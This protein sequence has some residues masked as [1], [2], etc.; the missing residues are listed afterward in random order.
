MNS[1]PAVDQKGVWPNRQCNPYAAPQWPS[2]PSTFGFLTSQ[3]CFTHPKSYVWLP[4]P[5]SEPSYW[6]QHPMDRVQLQ[7]LPFHRPSTLL[8]G[9]LAPAIF[10]RN[11]HTCSLNKRCPCPSHV[12]ARQILPTS[13]LYRYLF[14]LPARHTQCTWSFAIPQRAYTTV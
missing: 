3:R 12:L 5:C 2:A 4:T 14:F 13:V 9:T 11:C 6:P 8:S 1:D 10:R 7:R